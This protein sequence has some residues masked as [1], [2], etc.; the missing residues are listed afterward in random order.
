MQPKKK[1]IIYHITEKQTFDIFL[2]KMKNKLKDGLY[3]VGLSNHVG[4][5]YVKN[6]ELYF[7]NSDYANGYVTIEKAA[8]SN[9]FGS[10]IYVIANIT[11]NDFL[12]T[13]W[14]D[15]TSIPIYTE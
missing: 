10:D 5:L 13:S 3:F 12:I 1:I 14:I 6:N 2:A 11:H 9:V 8:Y 15:N 4:Y 7:L